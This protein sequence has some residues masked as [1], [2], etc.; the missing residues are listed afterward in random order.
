MEIYKKSH[1]KDL[2][3]KSRL[4]ENVYDLIRDLEIGDIFIS[5]DLF[6]YC[7]TNEFKE[8]FFYF[9]VDEKC[10]AYIKHEVESDKIVEECSKNR[11]YLNILKEHYEF[12]R[13]ELQLLKNSLFSNNLS[14]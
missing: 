1:E 4:N 7:I 10:V 14:I 13:E 11:F 3:L 12:N 6:F 9:L 8:I 2:T 5:N